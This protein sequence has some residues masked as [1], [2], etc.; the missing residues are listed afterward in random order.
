MKISAINVYKLLLPLKFPIAHSRKNATAVDNIV[1]EIVA[2]EN[3]LNGY[4]EGAPRHYVTGESQDTASQDIRSL[5]L[6]ERFPW[7]LTHVDQIWHFGRSVTTDKSQNAALCAL[8][9]ALLDVLARRQG[10][11]IL[12]YLPRE[13]LAGEV[14]YGGTIP[15][16]DL[17]M[18]N[19][20][21]E[22]LRLFDIREVRVKLGTDFDHSKVTLETVRNALGA[23]CDLR[24]DVNGAWDLDNAKRHL[25]I[26]VSNKVHILEQPLMPHDN[27]LQELADILKGTGLKLMADESVCSMKDLEYA[28]AE[29]YFDVVNVRLSK[30]GGFLNSLNIIQGVRASGLKYQVGCQL[31]ESGILS[32]AGRALCLISSDALYCDGSY[33]ALVLEENLTTRHVTFGQ[34]GKAGPLEGPGF[35]FTVNPD[36][37]NHFSDVA[38]SIDRP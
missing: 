10:H 24:V 25:P 12:H 26:L 31:G 7:N 19:K 22:M 3:G 18:V 23:E 4:G 16:A 11:N 13:Y 32:A 5:C 36:S 38:I 37:L 29:G 14:S 9:M 20:I 33:D 1:V 30:C 35:G 8:E 21:C 6:D 34:G 27:S 2:N 15:I 28:I 17:D